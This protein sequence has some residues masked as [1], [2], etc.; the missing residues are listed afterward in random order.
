MDHL[1]L[2]LAGLEFVKKVMMETDCNSTNNTLILIRK[3]LCGHIVE[4]IF[5]P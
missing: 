5:N 3:N 4:Q 2:N 1:Q